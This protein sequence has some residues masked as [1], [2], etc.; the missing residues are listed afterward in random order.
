MRGRKAI[1]PSE[2]KTLIRVF[3]KQKVI[4]AFTKEELEQQTNDFITKLQN[5]A[6]D[7]CVGEVLKIESDGKTKRH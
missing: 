4:D 6:L 2:K 1:D 5:D 3:V 7:K